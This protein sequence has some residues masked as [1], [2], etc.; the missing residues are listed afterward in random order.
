MERFLPPIYLFFSMSPPK[1]SPKTKAVSDIAFIIDKI[2]SLAIA[3]THQLV[4]VL[5]SN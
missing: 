2:M 3:V 1:L 4:S 5:F